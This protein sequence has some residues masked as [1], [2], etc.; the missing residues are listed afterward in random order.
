[1]LD[2]H[3]PGDPPIIITCQTNHALDQLLRHVA[4]VDPECFVRLGGRSKDKEIIK[5]RTI[6]EIREKAKVTL[7]RSNTKG[8]AS[9]DIRR[10]ATQM[11]RTLGLVIESMEDDSAKEISDEDEAPINLEVLKG[12]DILNEDQCKSIEQVAKQW[13]TAGK[14]ESEQNA[15]FKWAGTAIQASGNPT[16]APDFFDFEETELTAE[17]IQEIEAE[18][19]PVDDDDL[20]YLSGDYYRIKPWLSGKANNSSKPSRYI[21]QGTGGRKGYTD[22]DRLLKKNTDLGRV[23]KNSRPAL[24]DYMVTTLKAKICDNFRNLAV[25]YD[26]AIKQKKIGMWEEDEA[27]LRQHKVV[28]LTTTGFSK[29][30]GLIHSLH[31]RMVL[32]E[33]A[34]EALESPVIATCVESLEHLVLI[35]DHMQLRPHLRILELA[36]DPYYLD[37]SLFER[38]VSNGV[39]FTRLERQRRMVPEIR[40]LLGPIYGEGVIKDHPDVS[41]ERGYRP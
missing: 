22:A 18:A 28:G 14:S 21:I 10:I 25:Q 19:A 15:L 7:L 26:R 20:E 4:L 16:T 2:N 38:M 23:E 41:D 37:T 13:S 5:P 39:E 1:M 24:L 35:G 30:R 12:Y 6:Y 27:L 31:P 11:Q 17:E 34:A 3:C 8:M 29:Y 33:E 9:K 40:R 32:I 36:R